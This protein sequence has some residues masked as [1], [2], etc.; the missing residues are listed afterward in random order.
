M[1]VMGI[2]GGAREH[3]IAWKLS[4]SDHKPEIFWI[5]ENRN[6]GIHKICKDNQ[7]NFVPAEQ[8]IRRRL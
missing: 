5:A 4:L 3:A 1:R 6:P 2:G 8:R 7:E